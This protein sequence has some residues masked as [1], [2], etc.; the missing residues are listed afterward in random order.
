[1][2]VFDHLDRLSDERGLFEHALLSAPRRDHGYCVDDVARGLVVVCREPASTPTLDRLERLY[3]SFLVDAIGSDG[4][5][6]NRMG[7]DG[8]WHDEAAVGDWWGRAVWGLGVAAASGST[9]GIRARALIT[10]RLAAQQRSPHIRAM[11]YATLGAAEVVL[12]D[13]SERIAGELLS[14]ALASVQRSGPAAPSGPDRT[15]LWPEPRLRYANG[16]LAEA[17]IVAGAAL[18]EKS[19]LERGLALLTFLLATETR[20]GRLSVTPVG[21]RGPGDIGPAF[22][23]QPIEVAAIADACASAYRA[24]LDPRWLSG[25]QLAWKWFLGDNDSSTTMFDAE[26]GA[27][28]DGLEVGGRNQNQGAESTLAMLSTAQHARTISALR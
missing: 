4:R 17:L 5:C 23:Q 14:D 3:L 1:V 27:G 28:N 18:R 13:P 11:A 19:T 21:G 12:A 10:F 9:D 16:T 8:A 2:L 25:I 15:W 26:T 20:E 6:H 7:T 22:D 24:T